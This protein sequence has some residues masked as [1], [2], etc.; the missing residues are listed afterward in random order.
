MSCSQ[1]FA[2]KLQ[3]LGFRMTV[4]RHA[5]I[6]TLISAKKHLTPAEV[7]ERAHASAPGLTEPTVYRTLEF[8]TEKQ[9]VQSSLSPNGHLVYE[10]VESDH[11]HL[12]CRACGREVQVESDRLA[13]F[14]QALEKSTGFR[15]I[16]GTV[17]FIG[18]C[19]DCQKVDQN[20]G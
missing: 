19:P 16:H 6:H 12:V 2:E 20:G 9:I 15:Q 17:T 13:P 11:F 4:Q 1:P 14:A 10:L 8:L 7:Y 5:I 3:A 18:L